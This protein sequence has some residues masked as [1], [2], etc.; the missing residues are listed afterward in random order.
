MSTKSSWRR[1]LA[2]ILGLGLIFVLGTCSIGFV[3]SYKIL[4]SEII[5]DFYQGQDFLKEHYPP[6]E[7]DPEKCRGTC[8]IASYIN[9]PEEIGKSTE[10]HIVQFSPMSRKLRSLPA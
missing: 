1:H 5:R 8:P 3:Y 2:W 6:S 7:N 10:M 9:L 4:R